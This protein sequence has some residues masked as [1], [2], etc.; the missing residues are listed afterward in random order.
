MAA[1]Q[2]EETSFNCRN[3]ATSL[4]SSSSGGQTSQAFTK[5][6]FNNWA[7]ALGSKAGF[8][9]HVDSKT[10]QAAVDAYKNFVQ[11]KPI[12][13]LLCNERERQLSTKAAEIVKNRRT[14]GRIFNVVR[15]LGRLGIPFRGHDEHKES[16]NRGLFVE[17]I[18]YLAESGD[19][20]LKNHLETAPSNATYLSPQIQNEMIELVGMS[21]QA[22]VVEAVKNGRVFSV[23]MDETTDVARREQVSIFV[24]YVEDKP[25]GSCD[26]KERLLSIVDTTDC[27]GK[28]LTDLLVGVLEK[29]DLDIDNIVGQGCDC[30]SNMTGI[31]KGVQ[32]RIMEQNPAA[33]FTHCYC[34]SLNRALINSVSNKDN[35]QARDFFGTVE[36][37]YAFVEGS[38]LRHAYFIEC[39][40]R[41]NGTA[42]HLKGLSETR[43]NCRAVSLKRLM[44]PGVLSAVVETLEYVASTTS[45]GKARGTAV[46]LIA[47]ITKYEF[48]VSLCSLAPVLTVLN[49]VSATPSESED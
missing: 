42:L 29:N 32:A 12:D 22:A 17:L 23:L 1:I 34:H 14:D 18:G 4:P 41:I 43:W 27:T 46:G 5:D 10:H 15:F 3:F 11:Q 35:S 13:V 26:I 39:Q 19:S 2:F 49:E 9:A 25:D 37:L 45:D 30:G 6:G 44:E 38:A 36:L 31:N 24:R 33:L 28:G 47:T 48:I 40:Q 8:A 20:V 16:R 21:I 7:K